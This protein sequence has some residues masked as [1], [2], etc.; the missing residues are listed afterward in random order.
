MRRIFAAFALLGVLAVP[1][2][3]QFET[4]TARLMNAGNPTN[5][6][7]FQ[8][9]VDAFGGVIDLMCV[10]ERNF[11]SL[12]RD[13]QVAFFEI[14]SIPSE[15]F[16]SLS[17]DIGALNDVASYYD[18]IAEND[19]AG[20]DLRVAQVAIWDRM[21]TRTGSNHSGITAPEVQQF[22]LAAG[23]GARTGDYDYFLM[24]DQADLGTLAA[25]NL[26]PNQSVMQPQFGRV[27]VPEPGTLLLLASGLLGLIAVGTRRRRFEA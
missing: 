16:T 18:Y 20:R 3:A 9:D 6:P 11:V 19:L 5:T 14:N 24:F 10:D 8:W 21:G 26:L 22:Q 1:A 23:G 12:N 4:G 27:S 13:Y 2:Q 17:Y 15:Y 25:G 7:F